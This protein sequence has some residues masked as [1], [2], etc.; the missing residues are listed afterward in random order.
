MPAAIDFYFDFASPYGYFAA[1]RIE[2]L[3]ARCGRPV[4]W[5]PIMIGSAFKASGN[6]PLVEQ[7]LKG[8]YCRR[9]WDRLSRL[10]QVPYRFP[11]P[12]PVVALAPSRAFWWLSET[13]PE[14][15]V[16]FARAIYAAY[17]AAGR[18]IGEVAVTAAVAAELGLDGSALAAA[19][20]DPVWK[21]RLKAETEAA[22]ARGVFGSPFIIVEDEPFWG[23]DRLE[24]VEEWL[25]SS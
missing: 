12:F 19:V 1:A 8:P 24:M 7:P 6:V 4:A 18:N 25:K 11:E 13:R 17:F 22:I 20:A 23:A 16:P 14:A 21:Q 15:A 3:G 5:K 2:A 9:D 10:W